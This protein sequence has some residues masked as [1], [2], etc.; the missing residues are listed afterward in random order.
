MVVLHIHVRIA[1]FWNNKILDISFGVDSPRGKKK[2]TN[3]WQF[4]KKCS[5]TR[6]YVHIKAES[7]VTICASS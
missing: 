5:I 6:I 7:T 3:T 4:I 1:R 2:P